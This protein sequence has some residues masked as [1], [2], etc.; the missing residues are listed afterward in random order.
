MTQS[1]CHLGPSAFISAGQDL[2]SLSCFIWRT[3]QQQRQPADGV[4]SGYQFDFSAAFF[5]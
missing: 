5:S 3:K 4:S 2:N 1:H